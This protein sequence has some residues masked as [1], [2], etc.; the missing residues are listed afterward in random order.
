MPMVHVGY[1]YVEFVMLELQDILD[2][3]AT[4][5]YTKK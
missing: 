5:L 2:I 1:M 4:Q 3:T